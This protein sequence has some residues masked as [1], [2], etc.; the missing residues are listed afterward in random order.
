METDR[1][2]LDGPRVKVQELGRV[3]WIVRA[4]DGKAGRRIGGYMAG[5]LAARVLS[6]ATK[7]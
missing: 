6:R 3:Y 7:T 4:A 2:V 1:L 5:A